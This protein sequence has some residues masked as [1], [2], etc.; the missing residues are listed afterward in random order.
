M[1][2]SRKRKW[3]LRVA[4]FSVLAL[5]LGV[6]LYALDAGYRVTSRMAGKTWA[7]PSRV[8]ASPSILYPGAPYSERALRSSLKRLAYQPVRRLPVGVG[9]YFEGDGSFEIGLRSVRDLSGVRDPK[10]VRIRYDGPAIGKI[11]TVFPESEEGIF[12]FNLEPELLGEF[13]SSKREERTLVRLNEVPASLEDAIL[14]MEDRTF[15]SHHGLSLRGTLR[16]LWANVRGGKVAQGGS[17]L[18][19]QLMKNFFLKPERKL[20]RKI[21][22]AIMTLVAEGLYSKDQIFEAYL[23]EIYLG[24]RGP[25][26]IHGF[27]E[28]SKFYFSKP[29]GRTTLGEQALL[30]GLISSPGQYSPYNSV[31]RARN[32]R[33][34]VLRLLWEEQKIAREAYQAALAEPVEPRGK[35]TEPAKAPYF[36]DF[37][38][39]ELEER[40]SSLELT[41]EGLEIFTTLDAELQN[42]ALSAVEEMMTRL[43]AKVRRKNKGLDPSKTLQAVLVALQPQTGAIK[44]FVGG[45]NYEE[46][47]F[48]RVIQAMRQ[49]GSAMKPF[50]VATALSVQGDGS[51]PVASAATL[52]DDRPST[53][54]FA[55]KDWA[56]KNYE[57]VFGGTVTVRSAL[58]RSLNVAMVNLAS[59]VGLDRLTST[60]RSFGFENV[61]AF[62]SA[63][64][65]AIEVT[66]LH[67]ARAYTVF[68]NGGLQTD[69]F[70]I[71]AVVD[72]SGHRLEQRTPKMER[73]LSEEVAFLTTHL[74]QG[75]IDRGTAVSAR[76]LGLRG[77][78]AGKTGTTDG[79]R[80]SWFVGFSPS[81]LTVV[82]VGFDDD[83]PAGLTG[84]SGAL[85]V[86]IRFMQK[87]GEILPEE[88]FQ[89]PH[90]MVWLEIDRVRGCA[91]RGAEKWLEAFLPG[92]EPP[93]CK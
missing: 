60:F 23:N 76:K 62:P 46:S 16:A 52:L 65:G 30:V 22:E 61:S 66:P 31:E 33:N 35:V 15:Y 34:L 12:T 42:A 48:N 24:Q 58:E 70:G 50:V 51:P 32:R 64:L 57:D 39:R 85:Q 9:Q 72:P 83:T 21:R 81:L 82:W 1:A 79:E 38:R 27:G 19:Q 84:A 43:E 5:F 68:G 25:T 78:L 20:S 29:L 44:A 90:G 55:G 54:S 45:R 89:V 53:F 91:G 18:T 88:K 8:F 74:M 2:A 49:P 71:S 10:R 14:L 17:T 41:Q 37:V 87:A 92:T 80:D 7:L 73:V 69:P 11:L 47:Q 28:A 40:F 26:S 4:I 59:R 63:V 6:F 3:R 77:E 13:F 86:W 36:L 93:K 56:P 75:V 67:L